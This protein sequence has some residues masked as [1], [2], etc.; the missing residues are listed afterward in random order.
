M[1]NVEY[2]IKWVD[3]EKCQYK[4]G[5]LVF[6][7]WRTTLCEVGVP[8]TCSKNSSSASS[9]LFGV[10]SFCKC[11]MHLRNQEYQRKDL[12]EPKQVMRISL[13]IRW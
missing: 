13:S 11:F 8:S 12:V 2:L 5:Q 1:Q 6:P 10:A 3:Q 9:T 7:I 4:P